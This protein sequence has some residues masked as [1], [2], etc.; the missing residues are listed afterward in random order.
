MR[1]AKR[2]REGILVGCSG[3]V[4]DLEFRS[5]LGRIVEEIDIAAFV[6]AVMLWFRSWSAEEVMNVCEAIYMYPR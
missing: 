3:V 2:A 5:L 6:E 1:S 4:R